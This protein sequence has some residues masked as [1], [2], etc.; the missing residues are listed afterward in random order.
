MFKLS[1][2]IEGFNL[3]FSCPN[4]PATEIT[5][6]IDVDTETGEI[7]VSARSK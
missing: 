6:Y 4:R 7:E 5:R 1:G 2:L 3:S